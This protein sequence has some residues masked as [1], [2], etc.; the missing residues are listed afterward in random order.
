M[1]DPFGL[2]QFGKIIRHKH[3]SFGA[4]LAASRTSLERRLRK[5]KARRRKQEAVVTPRFRV[6]A[7]GLWQ[8]E[9]NR[10]LLRDWPGS[11]A[12]SGRRAA[13]NRRL[14]HARV[15]LRNHPPR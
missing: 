6:G 10:N 4:R 12:K 1:R 14:L 11:D 8:E 5:R 9:P 15:F 13:E 3:H 2:A 7:F